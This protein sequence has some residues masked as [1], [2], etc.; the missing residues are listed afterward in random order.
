[1]SKTKE[2]SKKDYN[3]VVNT[4]V[5]SICEMCKKDST[6]ISGL[7]ITTTEHEDYICK[8]CLNGY[9]YLYENIIDNQERRYKEF[10]IMFDKFMNDEFYFDHE[11]RKS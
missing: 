8:D 4:K 6:V 5:S 3:S 7:E 10:L 11:K 9:H 2:A 1:M